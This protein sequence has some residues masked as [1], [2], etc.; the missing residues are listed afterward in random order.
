MNTNNWF[1]SFIYQ[2]KDI[3]KKFLIHPINDDIYQILMKISNDYYDT[4]FYNI[5]TPELLFLKFL[6]LLNIYNDDFKLMMQQGIYQLSSSF[7]SILLK[8]FHIKHL[9]L[10]E[11]NIDYKKIYLCELNHYYYYIYNKDKKIIDFSLHPDF[12]YITHNELNTHIIYILNIYQP[13]SII[14]IYHHCDSPETRIGFDILKRSGMRKSL[15]IKS[16]STHIFLNDT[17]LVWNSFT[18]NLYI[19]LANPYHLSIYV[20]S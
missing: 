20:L 3:Y 11:L 13:P 6:K 2:T 19:S 10:F 17:Q 8:H 5:I 14:L 16:Y 4:T 15:D 18:Y 12:T 7:I 9:N 1:L